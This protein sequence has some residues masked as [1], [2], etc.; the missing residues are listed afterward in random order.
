MGIHQKLIIAK[1]GYVPFGQMKKSPFLSLLFIYYIGWLKNIWSQ[2]QIQ[3]NEFLFSWIWCAF[4]TRVILM[5]PGKWILKF[6]GE[7]TLLCVH[8][9]ILVLTLRSEYLTSPQEWKGSSQGGFVLTQ[10]SP[11]CG[12]VGLCVFPTGWPC[13]QNSLT[14][15]QAGQVQVD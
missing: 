12:S 6:M 1:T 7:K 9:D 3:W 5:V 8:L 4:S 14:D 15:F 10:E 11:H 13:G 2:W